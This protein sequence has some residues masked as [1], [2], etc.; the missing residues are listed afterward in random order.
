MLLK[1]HFDGVETTLLA[2]SRIAAGAGH[3]VN[4][5]TA[6]ELFIRE[7]LEAHLAS[8]V[9]IGQG[10]VIDAASEPSQARNQIDIVIHRRNYPKLDFGGGVGGFLAESG[11]ATIEVKS[12]LDRAAIKQAIGAARSLKSLQRSV[13]KVFTAGYQ[14]PS[15]LSYV[16]AYDGPASMHTVHGWLAP[17]HAELDISMPSLPADHDSRM[18]VVSPSLDCLVVLGKGFIGFDNSPLDPMGSWVRQPGLDRHWQVANLPDGNL[19]L[20]FMLMT[21]AVSG[22]EGSFLNPLPYLGGF[23]THHFALLP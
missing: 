20:L 5:G 13:T 19:L 16:V 10:E 9:A 6:R 14:P 2:Q 21:V 1:T 22:V 17:T 3:S 12:I 8:T 15:I 7:F 11:I 4:K 23:N 18:Q